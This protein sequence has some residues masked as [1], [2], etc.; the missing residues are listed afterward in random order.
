[1][2]LFFIL[3]FNCQ[4]EWIPLFLFF[5]FFYFPSL[6]WSSLTSQDGGAR[7]PAMTSG[8]SSPPAAC[9]RL[10]LPAPAPGRSPRPELPVPALG[11]SM[12][13][14]IS[15]PPARPELWPELAAGGGA[16]PAA[17]PHLRPIPWFNC[18]PLAG[19][20][21]RPPWWSSS[22]GRRLPPEPWVP[23]ATALA[24]LVPG[25]WARV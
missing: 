9:P 16:I 19:A 5:Y 15:R 11:R 12:P 25:G 4:T 8:R 23:P 20:R 6:T 1:M 22:S 18:K 21:P 2:C 17:A 13:A 3:F 10:E 24:E 14:R 7:P